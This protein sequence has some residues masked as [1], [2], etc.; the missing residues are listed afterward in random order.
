MLA[1]VVGAVAWDSVA[2]AVGTRSSFF[3]AAAPYFDGVR[4][5]VATSGGIAGLSGDM[6]H[7]L[8][9]PGNDICESG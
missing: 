3:G 2:A 8:T 6:S 1:G 9:L 4:E 7:W 5:L